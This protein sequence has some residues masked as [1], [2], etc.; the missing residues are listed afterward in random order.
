[1]VNEKIHYKWPCSIVMLNYQRVTTSLL[2]NYGNLKG[3]GPNPTGG[4][5]SRDGS[6]VQRAP[7]EIISFGLL[8]LLLLLDGDPV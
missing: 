2:H 4:L 8:I 6:F 3:L 1:M 7:W 5:V